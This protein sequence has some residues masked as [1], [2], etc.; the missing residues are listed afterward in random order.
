MV[1]TEKIA[2]FRIYPG[3]LEMG[4]QESKFWNR[5]SRPLIKSRVRGLLIGSHACSRTVGSP[6]QWRI[7][8]LREGGV[9]KITRM[10]IK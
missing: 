7:Q 4:G 3:A 1:Y 9:P 10:R 8:D 6:S 2:D 5:K